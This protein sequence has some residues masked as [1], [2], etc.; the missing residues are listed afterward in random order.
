MPIEEQTLRGKMGGTLN[1][2]SDSNRDFPDYLM[3][4]AP[5]GHAWGIVSNTPETR[6]FLEDVLRRFRQ[7]A[8]RLKAK[9]EH[10][11]LRQQGEQD[12][13]AGKPID[14]FYQITP[15]KRRGKTGRL[16]E[17]MRAE[18]EIGYRAAKGTSPRGN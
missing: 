11:A 14:A 5:P 3:W 15:P 17:S 7:D 1:A 12:A 9:D 8:S 6:K 4:A 13:L 18:Y 2:C 16:T 10:R